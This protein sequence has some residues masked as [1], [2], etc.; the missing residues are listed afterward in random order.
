MEH[1]FSK[2]Y[3]RLDNYERVIYGFSDSFE[4]PLET[5]IC[6]CEKGGRH[7]ELNGFS[8]PSLI[9]MDMTHKYKYISG[10]VVET[11]EEERQAELDS[12]PK[13]TKPLTQEDFALALAQLEEQKEKDKLELQLALAQLAES[14]IITGGEA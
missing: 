7:F 3:I 14:L 13:P 8:N 9:N 11:T 12:F 10:G 2:H 1:L 6:I 4:Q 5:D